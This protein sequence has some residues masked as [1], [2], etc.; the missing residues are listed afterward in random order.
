M[1]LLLKLLLFC[2]L[3]LKFT[4]KVVVGINYDYYQLLFYELLC[5]KLYRY[6]IFSYYLSSIFIKFCSD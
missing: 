1:F 3:L 5:L 6:K 4:L 2:E